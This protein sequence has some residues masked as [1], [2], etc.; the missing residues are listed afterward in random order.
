M[1]QS[2]AKNDITLG[3]LLMGATGFLIGFVV[4]SPLLM[5]IA[6][7]LGSLIGGLVGWIG[8]RRFLLIICVGALIGAYI[9]YRSGDHDILI[10]AAGSGAA[11][12]GFFGAQVEL[13]L[14]KK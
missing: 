10:I 1:L 9:G 2:N 8:G 7:V 5:G 11:I 6:G 4:H 14:R 12:S 3:V 13:F